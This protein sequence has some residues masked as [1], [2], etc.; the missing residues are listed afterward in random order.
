MSNGLTSPMPVDVI[1]SA[2]LGGHLT[3]TFLAGEWKPFVVSGRLRLLATFNEKRL[4]E[5]PDVPT[6]VDLGYNIVGLNLWCVVGPRA[7]QR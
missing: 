6:L 4:K 5:Y 1:I 7:S 2:V 3:C